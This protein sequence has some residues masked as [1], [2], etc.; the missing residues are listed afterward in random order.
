MGEICEHPVKQDSR[1][2]M[3]RMTS[4]EKKAL[5]ES[6]D[7]MYKEIRIGA[8]VHRTVSR[9]K[10]IIFM[11]LEVISPFANAVVIPISDPL[12]LH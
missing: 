2:A 3:N 8:E 10:S 4:Q 12:L 11:L 5:E 6:F 7:D 9:H 1:T